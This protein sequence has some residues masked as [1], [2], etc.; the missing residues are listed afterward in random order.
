MDS[1]SRDRLNAFLKFVVDNRVSATELQKVVPV[2]KGEG[3]AGP[4]VES[5]ILSRSL[6]PLNSGT[7]QPR[8]GGQTR[9]LTIGMATYDDYDGVYFTVQAIRLYHPEILE[10]VEFVIIDNNP[11]GPCG[12]ALKELGNWISNYRYIPRGETSGTAVR[13]CVFQEANG[14]FVLCIDC[15]I[16]IAAGALRRLLDYVE[17]HPDTMDLLQGPMIYDDLRGHATHFAPEWSEGMFGVWATDPRGADPD[18]PAFEIP[19]HGLGLFACRRSAW[20]GF[21][22]AFRGFGG[23]EGYIH[24]KLRQRGGKTLCLPFLRWLHRFGRPQGVAYP[25][26]WEDRV[27]NYL[28]GFREVGWDTAPVVTHFRALLGEPLWSIVLSRLADSLVEF[29]ETSAAVGSQPSAAAS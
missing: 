6:P 9:K 29:P 15:H 28:I 10:E 3:Q 4:E 27:R 23:E 17:G 24:E 20:P 5:L 8:E 18:Q 7:M 1:T 26:R 11:G 12:Q 21:N 25:N 19:M 2:L 22:P 16:L 13:D 14:E